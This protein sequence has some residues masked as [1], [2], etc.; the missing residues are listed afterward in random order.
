MGGGSEGG[1]DS[2]GGEGGRG[3][4]G[5]RGREAEGVREGDGVRGEGV[6]VGRG[7]GPV[8]DACCRLWWWSRPCHLHRSCC[9]SSSLLVGSVR[10]LQAVVA[11]SIKHG[12]CGLHLW[13][14]VIVCG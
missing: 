13:M 14:P 10:R 2:K 3:S 4:E 9:P 1:S 12:G 6:K 8:M 5:G 7:S 11:I